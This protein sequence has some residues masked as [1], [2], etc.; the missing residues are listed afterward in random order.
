MLGLGQ[1][2][3][4]ITTG[5]DGVNALYVIHHSVADTQFTDD[6]EEDTFVYFPG[7]P[8]CLKD[9][10]MMIIILQKN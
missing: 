3:Q 10:M 6:T 2:T 5:V 8:P 1:V 9:L 7:K 4:K